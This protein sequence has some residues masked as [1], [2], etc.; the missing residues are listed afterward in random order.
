MRIQTGRSIRKIDFNGTPRPFFSILP[1]LVYPRVRASQKCI[2]ISTALSAAERRAVRLAEIYEAPKRPRHLLFRGADAFPPPPPGRDEFFLPCSCLVC[3][4]RTRDYF[5]PVLR[6]GLAS[7]VY[8]R[9]GGR[10]YRGRRLKK[11]G[12]RLSLAWFEG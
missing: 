2:Y 11:G 1:Q 7:D 12:D 3:R 4:R 5:S 9:C 8:Q 6:N 10:S